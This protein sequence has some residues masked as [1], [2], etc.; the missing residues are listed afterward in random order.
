MQGKHPAVLRKRQLV[1]RLRKQTKI[2]H[3][4]FVSGIFPVLI[5]SADFQKAA[6]RIFQLGQPL[7]MVDP[8]QV[9]LIQPP[10][11]PQNAVALKNISKH[12]FQR[13]VVTC[14]RHVQQGKSVCH[15]I[16][17]IKIDLR[18]AA[19]QIGELIAV[20]LFQRFLYI[21]KQLSVVCAPCCQRMFFRV[22]FSLQSMV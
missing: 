19:V 17:Y 20:L 15:P 4:P 21:V 5:N 7:I 11:T 16:L 9:F 2:P 1:I 13:F 8:V 14:R 3:N 22:E 6:L 12:I 18:L 10:T